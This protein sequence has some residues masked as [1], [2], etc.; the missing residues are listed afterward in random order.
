MG[1]NDIS[2]NKFEGRKQA[3]LELHRNSAKVI[4]VSSLTISSVKMDVVSYAG[5]CEIF[6]KRYDYDM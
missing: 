6:M 3:N 1:T 4:Q 5:V 2:G